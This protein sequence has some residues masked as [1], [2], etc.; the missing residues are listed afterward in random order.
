MAVKITGRGDVTSSQVL[1]STGREVTYVPSP[2]YDQAHL[3]T[4]L[5][6]GI[7]HCFE[8]KSGKSVWEHRLGG[9]FRASLL[10][11]NG[12]IYATNDKGLTTVFR[13]SPTKFEPVAANDLDEICYATPAISNGRI[14]IRTQNHLYCVGK[15]TGT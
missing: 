15:G 13:A 8:A 5:D 10:L 6:D 1:W 2:V 12:H 9:R 11:A 3:F 4:V 7:L 14:Y